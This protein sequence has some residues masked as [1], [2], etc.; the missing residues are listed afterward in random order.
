MEAPLNG[1]LIDLCDLSTL[2]TDGSGPPNW[3][4][5]TDR[6]PLEWLTVPPN[7]PKF[8]FPDLLPA[9]VC[10]FIGTGGM[11]KSTLLLQR[12]ICVILSRPFLG[13]EPALDGPVL[14]VTK[15]DGADRLRYRLFQVCDQMGLNESAR[16]YVADNFY[17]RDFVGTDARLARFDG[18]G[19]I[20]ITPLADQIVERY[21]DV[22]P[23]IVTFDPL[24][25]F[26]PGERAPNDA[27]DATINAAMRLQRALG[28]A[29]ELVHHTSKAVVRDGIIDHHTGRGGAALGDGARAVFQLVKPDANAAAGIATPADIEQGNILSLHVTKLTDAKKPKDPIWIRRKGWL[30]ER[31]EIPTEDEA[32]A[33]ARRERERQLDARIS[34][35]VTYVEEKLRQTPTERFTQNDLVDAR[36]QIFDGIGRDPMRDVIK[37][38]LRRGVLVEKPLPDGEKTRG[39]K[40]HFLAPSRWTL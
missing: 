29:V 3:G 31:I 13:I 8:I 20:E 23:V 26:S 27:E 36:N 5:D 40:Y 6:I 28:C 24:V 1:E 9:D 16:K 38:A 37:A 35:L 7:E 10:A 2:A 39:G 30:F 14:Y 15:E 19:N 33:N 22:N 32:R 25:K 18:R 11:G 34:A 12:N 17:I 21:A 4:P